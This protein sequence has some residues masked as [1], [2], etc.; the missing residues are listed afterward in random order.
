MIKNINQNHLIL[1]LIIMDLI[2]EKILYPQIFLKEIS[3]IMILNDKII[4]AKFITF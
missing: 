4:N 3:K 2:K 1:V